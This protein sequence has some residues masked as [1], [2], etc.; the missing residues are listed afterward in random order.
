MDTITAILVD[1]GFYRKQ[2][3]KLFGEKSSSERA[4]ELVKYCFR[5]INPDYDGE[6]KRLYR[7]FYYDCEPSKKTIFNPI[8]QKSVNLSKTPQYSWTVEFFK[9]LSE[10]RKLALRMGELSD[11]NASYNLK[12][13]ITKKLL[14]NEIEV[15]SITE[16]DLILDIQQKGVDMRIGLD[17]A[18]L[19]FKKL[20]NQIVL[21]AGDSDFVPAAKYARRE[22]IDFILDPLRHPIKDS[23]NL[24]IDGKI[25]RTGIIG[26]NRSDKLCN[27][28]KTEIA[29]RKTI[30]E[31]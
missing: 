10:Q 14:K 28:P 2:A 7:I 11:T 24:H 20:V 31:E 13:E 12:P 15:E 18:S 22:D 21:I 3:K 9:I 19:A 17:I 26:N 8:T 29:V 1:G 5:H 6:I 25:T 27:I 16:N 23:L 30:V 4:N